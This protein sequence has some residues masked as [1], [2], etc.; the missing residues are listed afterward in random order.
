METQFHYAEMEG[1]HLYI[2]FLLK[3]VSPTTFCCSG[4]FS[5][6]FL[7]LAYL[8]HRITFIFLNA[9]FKISAISYFSY[10]KE[11]GSLQ[12]AERQ[13]KVLQ[14]TPFSENK[15][16]SFPI[17]L[18]CCFCL[19]ENLTKR[20]SVIWFIAWPT[21]IFGSTTEWTET[22]SQTGDIFN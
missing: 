18:I 1:I 22:S 3:W 11:A 7:F 15:G 16:C 17:F 14:P 12:M 10:Q 19:L 13:L 9:S 4:S 20:V 21:S 2:P 5:C 6:V 8:Y